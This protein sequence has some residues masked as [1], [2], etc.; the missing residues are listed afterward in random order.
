MLLPPD[1]CVVNRASSFAGARGALCA[2]DCGAMGATLG[3]VSSSAAK[4]GGARSMA[5][6]VRE[7]RSVFIRLSRP[8]RPTPRP[9]RYFIALIYYGRAAAEV[10]ALHKLNI[11]ACGSLAPQAP[12]GMCCAPALPDYIA[13]TASGAVF[14]EGWPSG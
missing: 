5:A 14:L 3:G 12:A 7:A 10:P 13:F 9:G 8:E 6:P 11:V 4:Q 2:L 1:H